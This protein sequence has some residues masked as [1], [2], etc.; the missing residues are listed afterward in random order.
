MTAITCD[1]G[2]LR[3][4]RSSA[5]ICVTRFRVSIPAIFGNLGDFG[6]HH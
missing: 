4:Q 6:N 5:Q 2:D 1:H 3:Y